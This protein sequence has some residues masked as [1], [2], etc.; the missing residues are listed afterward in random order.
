MFTLVGSGIKKF[1]Q[2]RRPMRNVMPR[3]VTWIQ[4]GASE[5][6]PDNKTVVTVNGNKVTVT[7]T[8]THTHARAHTHMVCLFVCL[9]VY[10]LHVFVCLI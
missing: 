5:F 1:E 3:H 2:T 8:H 9:F 4:D 7:H 10:C 6:D